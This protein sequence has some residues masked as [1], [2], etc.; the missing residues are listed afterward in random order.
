MPIKENAAT[1]NIAPLMPPDRWSPMLTVA[2][3]V[4]ELPKRADHSRFNFGF[5]LCLVLAVHVTWLPIASVQ[6]ATLD[7]R[8]SNGYD[9]RSRAVVRC[10]YL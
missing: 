3:P 6:T 4:V 9:R 1:K 7:L 5:L 10:D 8:P 2:L